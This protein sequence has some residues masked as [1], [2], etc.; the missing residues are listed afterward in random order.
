VTFVDEETF[1]VV[2][3]TFVVT[4]ADMVPDTEGYHHVGV[5]VAAAAAVPVALM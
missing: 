2:A 1:A 5:V 3:V 4:I